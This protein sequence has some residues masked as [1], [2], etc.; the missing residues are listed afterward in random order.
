[1]TGTTATAPRVFIS[2]SHDS[3]DH[4]AN[5]ADFAQV[6]RMNGIDARIDQFI[7][8]TPPLSWPKWMSDE[9]ESAD[10]VLLV[11]TETYARRFAGEET[12]GAGHGVR[13]E[14]SLITSEMYFSDRET[15]RFIPVVT[16]GDDTKHIAK[17]L[18][19]TTFYEI[20]YPGNRNLDALLRALHG[21]PL[22]EP[23]PI[24]DPPS[25]IQAD[26]ATESAT[27][28][29]IHEAW[30]LLERGEHDAVIEITT[31]ILDSGSRLNAASAAVIIGKIKHS[32]EQYSAAI[33]AFQRALELDANPL[34]N[35]QASQELAI[36]LRTMNAH[37]GLDSAVRAGSDYLELIKHGKI[38]EVWKRTDKTLRTVL[39]QSWIIAN[40][41][42]PSLVE[43]DRDSLAEE[44]IPLVADNPL[45]KDFFSTQIREMQ[46]AFHSYD[47]ERW[48][49]AERPRRFGLDYELVVFMD[50]GGD[51][52][53]FDKGV[54]PPTIPL[55][56]RRV[57]GEWK[58]ASFGPWYVTPGWPPGQ[59]ALPGLNINFHRNS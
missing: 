19:L 14:A 13:W 58:V 1:M 21:K 31:P 15:V 33:N 5:I 17:P 3:V 41:S 57:V 24:G 30:R 23:L 36:V 7:Q 42:H 25:F 40:S 54:S 47:S 32:T 35:E 37:Y 20:G 27:D 59:E 6:L 9:V 44:L 45:R 43:I 56:L 16:S 2:Y 18:K 51:V 22:V 34:L 29:R 8:S 50:T 4:T 52:L 11:F 38:Q 26:S 55:L 53:V 12:S 28:D 46:N 10:V 39:V 49:A 48:G